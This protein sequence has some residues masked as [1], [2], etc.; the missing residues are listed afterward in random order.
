MQ[1]KKK[2]ANVIVTINI[3]FTWTCLDKQSFEYVR[4]LNIARYST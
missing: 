2:K 4:V 3:E 1:V